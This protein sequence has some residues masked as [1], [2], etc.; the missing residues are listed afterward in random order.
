MATTHTL[1]RERQMEAKKE[2]MIESECDGMVLLT[3]RGI[4]Q[5]EVTKFVA[6]VYYERNDY[7]FEQ[8][9]EEV[10]EEMLSEDE[11]YKEYTTVYTLLTPNREIIATCRTIERPVHIPLPIEREFDLNLYDII[12]QYDYVYRNYEIARLATR[13][14]ETKCLFILMR[15]LIRKGHPSDFV[16]ASLDSRVLKGLRKIGFHWFDLGEAK[17]YLGSK[18]CPVGMRP[19]ENLADR[20]FGLTEKFKVS[21]Q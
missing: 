1:G 6:K 15:E 13:T 2:F 12:D 19:T 3:T 18:T 17:Y 21:N 20:F 5:P 8:S 11:I 4:F 7:Q 14:K 10:L 9:F 16:V